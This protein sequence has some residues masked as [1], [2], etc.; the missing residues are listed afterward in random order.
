LVTLNGYL[1]VNN[2][3]GLAGY[4]C[5]AK[6]I[7][8]PSVGRKKLQM[9]SFL[10]CAFIF[11]LTGAIFNKTSPQVLMFLYFFSSFVVNFGPNVTSYVMAAETYP[12]ELR[13]TCHGISAFMGKAGALF[14]TIIFGSLTSAQIFFLCG[15]T[16]IIG[17]LFTLLF[18]VDLTHVSL[19]EHDAQLEL[20]LE[21]RLD[22]YKGK[23]NSPKHLS[24]YER[25][26]G[27]HGEYD[28][29]W[30]LKLLREVENALG[31]TSMIEIE[32]M[33]IQSEYDGKSSASL[34]SKAR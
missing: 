6:V 2:L 3:C 32:A 5:A 1:L 4:Y 9:I 20:F 16:C 29:K 8:M 22:E 24:L 12:T 23:L 21:G 18:S 34:K 26:T 19:S 17:A 10:V 31:E 15:G 25:I 28:P 30:A 13:G 14:A 7:D 27:R 33:A 11:L